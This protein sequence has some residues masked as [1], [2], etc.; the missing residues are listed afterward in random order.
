MRECAA[1]FREHVVQPA[2][3]F[4][5]ETLGEFFSRSRP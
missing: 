5:S 3:A 2:A 4:Y 1:G